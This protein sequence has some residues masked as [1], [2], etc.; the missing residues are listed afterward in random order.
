MTHQL[1]ILLS[2][3]IVS[4][5]FGASPAA[6]AP[7]AASPAGRP[8]VASPQP[9][10]ADR[11]FAEIMKS[12]RPSEQVKLVPQLEQFIRDY[13]D[14]PRIEAVYATLLN[15]LARAKTE[16]ER[17]QAL[18]D[19]A[20]GKFKGDESVRWTAYYAK[21][22]VL[23]PGSPEFKSLGRRILDSET[24]PLVLKNAADIDQPDAVALL[25]KAIAEQGK[26]PRV[27]P[28]VLGPD[29]LRW[30]YAGA[31]TDAGRTDEGLK[32]CIEI[33]DDGA[34]RLAEF[35]RSASARSAA[36]QFDRQR[37]LL[38][39]RCSELVARCVSAGRKDIA[40][41]YLTLQQH[42]SEPLLDG[43]PD[44]L[45]SAGQMY[46]QLGRPDLALDGFVRA[47]ARRMDPS[48]RDQIVRLAGKTGK[49]P[50]D[51]YTRA[52]DLRARAAKP[53][54]PFTLVTSDGQPMK[55]ADIR[56]RVVLLSFFYPT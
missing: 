25:E 7:R 16:P 23:Q 28:G 18:A 51:F 12:A 48:T 24:N 39:D 14:Y 55:L 41:R 3:V 33:V 43:R 20:L 6:R 36:T 38:A 54:Y 53:A 10:D 46:E 37:E 31:L 27:G 50:E 13:P 8:P 34:R 30:A 32:K 5:A 52:R 22:S 40:L 1:A 19:Q 9:G 26:H 56:A 29:E 21:F 45:A 15:A 47:M 17:L 44:L 49:N 2:A 42:A 35:E 11:K 4:A